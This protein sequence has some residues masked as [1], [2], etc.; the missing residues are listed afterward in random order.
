MTRSSMSIPLPPIFAPIP[1]LA[2]PARH[3]AP[4]GLGRREDGATPQSPPGGVAPPVVSTAIA[5]LATTAPV[6]TAVL[7]TFEGQAV[8]RIAHGDGA[9]LPEGML[10]RLRKGLRAVTGGTR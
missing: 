6:A 2:R 3:S 10:F 8:F 5:P 1:G 7:T 4:G 9:A